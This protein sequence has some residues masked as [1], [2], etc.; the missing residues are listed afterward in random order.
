MR[1]VYFGTGSFAI[2]ALERTAE[3]VVLVVTQ[4][5]RPTGRGMKVQFNSVHTRA[6][7]LGIPVATPERARAAEFVE[8]I[9][10]LK[11]DAL[12]VASYGQILSERLLNAAVRGGI[13]LHGSI[14]PDG[15]G[16]APIQR[17]VMRGDHETGITLMQMD[18]GMD[19][20]DIIEI[21]RL[22]IG[23]NETYGEL[24]ERMAHRAAGLAEHWMPR[25]IAGDYPRT[26][27][28]ID[29]VTIAP[30]IDPAETRLDPSKESA[31]QLHN[32]ARGLAPDY[33]PYIET[34]AGRLRV[35]RTLLADASGDPGT[36]T[37][38]K[39]LTIATTQ[40][41]LVLDLVQPAGK[42][43]MSGFDFANGAR[44]RPGNCLIDL[45]T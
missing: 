20:G 9:E 30:K 10:A 8:Q 17:S 23:E 15:R 39:P 31:L 38:V 11:P 21:T 28:P 2:P 32:R 6:L 19:T 5:P 29:G 27:Q 4:P 34:I 40:D 26:P 25:I 45:A 18:R 14:L 33:R 13:N 16:A 43:P 35:L 37:S 24:S 41:G 36:F 12:L 3:H 44:L 7:E 22:P 1:L 42:R